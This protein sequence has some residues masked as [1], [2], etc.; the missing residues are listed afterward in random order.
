MT[1]YLLDVNV[2]LVLSLPRHQH[3]AGATEWFDAGQQRA[4]TPITETA[5]LRLMLNPRVV[6]YDIP[7]SQA[8]AALSA[9]LELPGHSFVAD[10]SSL[11][12]PALDVTFLAGTKQVTDFH[13][14]NLAVSSSM[15]FA[16]FDASLKRALAQSYRAHV[17]VLTD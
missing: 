13:L 12:V 1:R 15:Q 5:Y 11:A 8:L 16:T 4:T 6:G 10:T 7:A 2:L 14:V 17:F 3:H 9:M